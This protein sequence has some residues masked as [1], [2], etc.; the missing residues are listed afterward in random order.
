MQGA[1]KGPDRSLDIRFVSRVPEGDERVRRVCDHCD[2][3]HYQNPKIV[4]GA[5]ATHGEEILLCRR[6]IP[7]RQGYWTIPA[8]YLELE[9]TPEQGAR[10]EAFEEARAQLEIRDLLAVY[11]VPRISQVQLFYRARLTDPRVA[12]GTESL[13][14]GLF[15]W[16]AIPW[17]EL[18]FP[19]VRWALEHHRE[20]AGRAVWAP[21]TNPEGASTELPGR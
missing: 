2:F 21:R 12:P 17:D 13:E 15:A 14:V 16:G 10:R 8:G 9:E 20:A 5:V 3:V 18:A 6:A 7:P 1:G 19:T 11:S 4:V